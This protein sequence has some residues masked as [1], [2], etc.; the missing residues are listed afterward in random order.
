[1]KSADLRAALFM[2]H[3][4]AQSPT[5]ARRDVLLLAGLLF[6]L[7]VAPFDA[8]AGRDLLPLTLVAITAIVLVTAL[9]RRRITLRQ[10]VTRSPALLPLLLFF[11]VAAASNKPL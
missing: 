1:M 5:A 3:D 9:L 7:S 11:A 2:R 8:G 6:L 10:P 4:N